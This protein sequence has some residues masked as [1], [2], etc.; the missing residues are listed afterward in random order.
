MDLVFLN[1]RMLVFAHVSLCVCG[2]WV[3]IGGDLFTVLDM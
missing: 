2:A 3:S 1:F